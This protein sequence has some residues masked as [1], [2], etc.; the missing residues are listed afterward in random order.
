MSS[1]DFS[2]VCRCEIIASKGGK[3]DKVDLKYRNK[4]FYRN[5][6]FLESIQTELKCDKIEEESSYFII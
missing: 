4:L 5:Y 3:R 6:N 1:V 2:P